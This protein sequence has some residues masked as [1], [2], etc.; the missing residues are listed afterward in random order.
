[1]RVFQSILLV[2]CHLKLCRVKQLEE[3]LSNNQI[4]FDLL[5]YYFEEGQRYIYNQ[6]LLQNSLDVER[7]IV[8]TISLVHSSS[9]LIC[10]AKDLGSIEER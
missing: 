7:P 2:P 4:S 10:C 8:G 5:E 3:L 1:V 6:G 9:P